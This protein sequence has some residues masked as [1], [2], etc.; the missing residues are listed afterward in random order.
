[1]NLGHRIRNPK[2]PVGQFAITW[3][4]F[5]FLLGPLGFPNW[6][7]RFPTPFLHHLPIAYPLGDNQTGSFKLEFACVKTPDLGHELFTFT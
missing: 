4:G 3:E 1:M 5:I 2:G 6:H 7:H